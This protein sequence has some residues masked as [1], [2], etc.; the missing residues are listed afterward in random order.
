MT[1]PPPT[2]KE[3]TNSLFFIKYDLSGNVQFEDK[4][5]YKPDSKDLKDEVLYGGPLAG[6]VIFSLLFYGRIAPVG[7]L[8]GAVATPIGYMILTSKPAEEKTDEE[9]ELDKL[10]S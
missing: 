3:K 2:D 7:I 5:M 1:T 6:G 8:I 10:V 4:W 9:K